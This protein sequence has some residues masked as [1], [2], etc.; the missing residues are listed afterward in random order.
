[1]LRR[2]GDGT[3][4]GKI[5]KECLD[6]MWDGEGDADAIIAK[7]GPEQI[8]DEGRDREHRRRNPRRQ[9]G[10]RR[11]I[12]AGKEKRSRRWSARRWARRR[13]RRIPRSQRD[14]KRKLGR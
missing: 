1:M 9:P 7:K 5:A 6:A 11:G 14:L 4:S 10:N 13:A 2:I 3:I 8:S 12:P